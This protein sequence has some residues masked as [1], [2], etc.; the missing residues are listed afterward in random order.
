[1]QQLPDDKNKYKKIEI[2]TEVD[3]TLILLHVIIITININWQN[4]Y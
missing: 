2:G 1:M 4:A 3:L